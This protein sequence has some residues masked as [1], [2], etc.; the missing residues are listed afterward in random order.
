MTG[1]TPDQNHM[2]NFIDCVRTRKKPNAPVEIGYRSAVAA[3]MA[4]VA[5]RGQQRV[6]FEMAKT[7]TVLG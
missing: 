5:Y 6:S 1:N 7:R 4:N 2:L 3:H